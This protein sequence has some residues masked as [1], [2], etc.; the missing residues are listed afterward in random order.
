[1]VLQ[2]TKYVLEGWALQ[3]K[4]SPNSSFPNTMESEDSGQGRHIGSASSREN[5]YNNHSLKPLN[6]AFLFTIC[7]CF[8]FSVVFLC[9]AVLFFVS[10]LLLDF[11]FWRVFLSFCAV[12]ASVLFF[13]LGVSHKPCSGFISKCENR[14]GIFGVFKSFLRFRVVLCP[15]CQ[16]KALYFAEAVSHV[17]SEGSSEDEPKRKEFPFFEGSSQK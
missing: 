10:P 11:P 3:M 17:N 12:S 5:S 6:F 13:L 15:E 4:S 9:F 8:I 7:L 2:L 1:M 16:K 14:V